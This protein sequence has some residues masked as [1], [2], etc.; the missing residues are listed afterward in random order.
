MEQVTCKKC[1]ATIL[2]TTSDKTGGVCMPCK[3]GTRESMEAAKLYYQRERELDKTC[4]FRKL[5]RELVHRV[6]DTDL[7]Y[8]GLSDAEKRYFAVGLLEGEVYNGG[9]D[10]YFFN[11][12][13]S[14]YSDAEMGLEEMGAMQS[15]SLLRRAKQIVFGDTVIPED[16][17][18]RREILLQRDSNFYADQLDELDKL[19]WE[20]PD[21]LGERNE[22]FA[23]KHALV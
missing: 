23:R 19:F 18:Q 20:D 22:S 15:L 10:Q 9:F 7:G 3:N 5:W 8:A 14:Y 17:E 4:P 21:G 16:T 11:S 1:G 6:H 13:G 2:Q 12:S